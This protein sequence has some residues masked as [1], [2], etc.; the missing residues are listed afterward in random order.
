MKGEWQLFRIYLTMLTKKSK[1]LLLGDFSSFHY[2]LRCELK[3]KGYNVNVASSGD[4]WKKIPC[5]IRLSYGRKGLLNKV[6]NQILP[7]LIIFRLIGYDKVQLIHTK[8]LPNYYLN[9]LFISLIF[10]LNKDVYLVAC[11]S[12]SRYLLQCKRKILKYSPYDS[13]EEHSLIEKKWIDFHNKVV[14]KVKA[15]IPVLYEYYLPYQ[16]EPNITEVIPLLAPKSKNTFKFNNKIIF[17]HGLIRED[18]KGSKYIRRAFE[19]LEKEYSDE[20][21]FIIDGHMPINEYLAIIDKTHVIVDQ[22][23]SYGYGINGVIALSKGKILMSGAE[24][25]SN[26]KLSSSE[27]PVINIVPNEKDIYEKIKVL[28][29][30]RDNLEKLSNNSFEYFINVHNPELIYKKYISVW[31]DYV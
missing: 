17:F 7:L 4:G 6:L 28:I 26:D 3:D 16:N 23:R 12:D 21:E 30:N 31:K 8:I 15:I 10:L 9:K 29:E 22:C 25:E 13:L 19:K 20:A 1:I 27:C 14:K 5:D 18:F 11:G 2:N 24:P